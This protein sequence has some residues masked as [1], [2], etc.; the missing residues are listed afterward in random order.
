[1]IAELINHLWQS[2]LFAVAAA[3][4]TVALRK[5]RAEIRYRLWFSASLKLFVPFFLLMSI[6]GYWKWAP[7]SQKIAKQIAPPSVTFTMAPFSQPALIGLPSAS[8]ASD[9]TPILILFVWMCGFCAIAAMRLQMWR[10]IRAAVR[11]SSPL[12]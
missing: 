8:N 11:T 4:L 10:R 1:M 6:G 12:E 9:W 3:L 5:N 7:A 2:T